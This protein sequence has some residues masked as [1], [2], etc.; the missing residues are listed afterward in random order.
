MKTKEFLNI[1]ESNLDKH[2]IFEYAP[3]KWVGANYHI[4]EV[5]NTTINYVDCG[6]KADAWQETVVQLWEDQ[7]GIGK[8]KYLKTKKAVE[9]FT[10]ELYLDSRM[11]D[12]CLGRNGKERV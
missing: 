8:R 4:T 2:L 11:E 6:G 5:K 9:I 1:I 12:L 10:K 3:A 7:M